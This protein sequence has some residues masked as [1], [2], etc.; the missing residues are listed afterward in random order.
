MIP[1]IGVAWS[2]VISS[3]VSFYLFQMIGDG[4]FLKENFDNS[5]LCKWLDL[6]GI[7]FM[8]ILFLVSAKPKPCEFNAHYRQ[9]IHF[10]WKIII[11]LSLEKTIY[12]LFVGGIKNDLTWK[13]KRKRLYFSTRNVT[14]PEKYYKIDCIKIDIRISTL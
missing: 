2:P 11:Y 12:L 7:F 14:E 6:P 4:E 9:L 3:D 13:A 8:W 1:V 5:F 10:I